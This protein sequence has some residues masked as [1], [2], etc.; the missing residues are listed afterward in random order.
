[1]AYESYE[2]DIIYAV[3]NF[4]VDNL[5][6]YLTGIETDKADGITLDD[7]KRYEV[8]DKDIYKGN[9]YPYALFNPDEIEYE[10]LSIQHDTLRM[11]ILLT[12]AIKTADTE[13]L[14]LKSMR[15]AAAIRQCINSDYTVGNAVD[16]IKPTSVIHYARPVGIEDIKV[17]DILLECEKC[18]PS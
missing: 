7:I 1:M 3:K 10:P 11:K 6:T 16:I 13:K 2:E 15:Y 17:V 4:L 9:Q 14:T 5:K 18:I 8:G 12:V